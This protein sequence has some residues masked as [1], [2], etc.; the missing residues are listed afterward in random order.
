M[1]LFIKG[2]QKSKEIKHPIYDA[3]LLKREFKDIKYVISSKK[4]PPKNSFPPTSDNKIVHQ[5]CSPKLSL[6]SYL[7]YYLTAFHTVECCHCVF[8][9]LWLC[10]KGQ[11]SFQN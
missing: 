9:S 5:K 6:F 11:G 8:S 4:I 10:L 1:S 2:S 3:I 7:D